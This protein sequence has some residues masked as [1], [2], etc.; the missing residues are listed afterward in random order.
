MMA[1]VWDGARVA[2][3]HKRES[4]QTRARLDR[5]NRRDIQAG[6]T[7]ISKTVPIETGLF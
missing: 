5:F 6:S 1:T 4:A 2:A 7:L 3:E